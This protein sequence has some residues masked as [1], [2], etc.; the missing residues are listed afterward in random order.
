MSDQKKLRRD[1][2]AA[3]DALKHER[4]ARS[5]LF[6]AADLE[7]SAERLAAQAATFKQ[8]AERMKEIEAV[9]PAAPAEE[10]KIKRKSKSKTKSAGAT[11]KRKAGTSKTGE[12]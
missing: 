8:L 2:R 11:R 1:I 10:A 9:A 5:K 4:R 6:A 7:G 12:N 3:W